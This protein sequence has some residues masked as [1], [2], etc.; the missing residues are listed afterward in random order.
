[1]SK[2][3]LSKYAHFDNSYFISL[4]YLGLFGVFMLLGFG[5]EAQL[6]SEVEK[7]GDGER[8]RCK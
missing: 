6:L 4:W 3:A 1:M 7:K 5:L 2:A 8:K